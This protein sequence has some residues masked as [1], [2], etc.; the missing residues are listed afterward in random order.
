MKRIIA[1]A[2]TLFAAASFMNV[3]AQKYGIGINGA[4]M[5]Y[6]GTL[7]AEASVSV[8]RRITVD[9]KA[10]YNPWAYNHSDVETEVHRKQ[11]SAELGIRYWPWHVYSG[12]WAGL[13]GRWQEYNRNGLYISRDDLTEEGDA[14]G[15]GVS[16]G[17]TMMLRPNLNI[18]FGLGMW[19]GKTYYRT[20]DCPTC[21][22]PVKEGE[23]WFVL[24]SEAIVSLMYIF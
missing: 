13:G 23:K 10:H 7:N 18:E 24:P 14:Y 16:G 21:G 6:Y 1:I 2:V 3:H 17:Y 5:L 22:M 9:A 15:A 12:W 19:A 11:R 20:Y 4:E 8:A